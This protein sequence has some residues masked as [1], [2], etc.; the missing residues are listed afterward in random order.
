M[1]LPVSDV[2]VVR[3]LPVTTLTRT[4]LDCLRWLPLAE[5]VAVG[6]AVLRRRRLTPEA[7]SSSVAAFRPVPPALGRGP[8][9]TSST[10][11]A[12]PSW[13][14]WPGSCWPRPVSPRP[15]AAARP[16]PRAGGRP[17]RLAWPDVGLVV[18]VD[19]FAFHSQRGAVRRDR[20]GPTSSCCWGGASRGSA[21]R[22]W[23]ASRSA[24]WRLCADPRRG[25][26]D[27]VAG[28]GATL[29]V[30]SVGRFT[31]PAVRTHVRHGAAGR[32]GRGEASHPAG[33]AAT[34]PSPGVT[35]ARPGCGPCEGG[36]R[37]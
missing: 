37:A 17:G 11:G 20:P 13:S 35:S 3:G 9:R 7:V 33:A 29:T 15:A 34:P 32:M 16:G 24:W 23:W 21:G 27:W 19:G 2:T 28:P 10:R 14:R 12:S 26:R 22:K 5:A 36:G 8:R 31:L 6:D 18:E 25:V 4:L 1:D 30:L